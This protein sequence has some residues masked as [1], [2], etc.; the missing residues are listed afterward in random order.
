MDSDFSP[1][2]ISCAKIDPAMDLEKACLFGC[3]ISTGLGAVWNTCKVAKGTSVAVFGLGAV[4]L[5]VIQAA[6]A[7]GATAIA[8]IDVN[9]KKFDIAKKLG[10]T[11]SFN[12]KDYPDK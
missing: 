2:Q 9:P 10:M 5:A 1:S 3:G 7:A 12:P 6:K 11:H 4:G 8:G